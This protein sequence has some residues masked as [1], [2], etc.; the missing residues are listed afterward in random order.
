LVDAL[1]NGDIRAA[2][3][4]VTDPE[5]IHK[6]HELCNLENCIIVPHIGTATRECRHRMAE[7][8]AQNILKHYNLL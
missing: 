8:A 1:K 2:G 5:P 3:L 7:I 6:D 4:D